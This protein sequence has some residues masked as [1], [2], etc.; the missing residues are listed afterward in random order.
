MVLIYAVGD[1]PTVRVSCFTQQLPGLHSVHQQRIYQ[2]EIVAKLP[3]NNQGR[4]MH[5]AV[6]H[7][8]LQIRPEIW[9]FD[10][11]RSCEHDFIH[12]IMK[13]PL[14]YLLSYNAAMMVQTYLGYRVGHWCCRRE[15]KM[16]LVQPL[17]HSLPGRVWR[18]FMARGQVPI[19]GLRICMRSQCPFATKCQRLLG[20]FNDC[21]LGS[22]SS[23]AVTHP[24]LS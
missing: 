23:F 10:R 3:M 14:H 22:S 8:K 6:A 7:H 21:Q 1:K 12:R 13:S 9:Q 18:A 20:R 11:D 15:G 4:N 16:T 2:I 17:V 19:R 5:C 24:H